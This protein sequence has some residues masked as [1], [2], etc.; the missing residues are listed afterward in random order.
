MPSKDHFP[1]LYH[2]HHSL[3]A[4]DLP[5]WLELASRCGGPILE[6][7]CGTGRVLVPLAEAGHRVYG[8]DKDAG[9]LA[10]LQRFLN[11]DIKPRVHLLL[12]DFAAI[13]LLAHF[14]LILMPCNTYS[15]LPQ[16]LRY[17]VL[18]EVK[19][20]LSSD[21]LFAASL[22]NPEQMRRLPRQGEPQIEDIFFH[23]ADGEPVQ[24]SSRW[25]RRASQLVIIWDYDHLSPDGRVERLST[26]VHHSLASSAE[27][28]AEFNAAGLELIALYGDYD[29]SEY[30][31]HSPYLIL[32]AQAADF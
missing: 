19:A 2:A 4:E 20:C 30:T 10:V 26:Q 12:G 23:P 15:T 11:S 6:L 1:L 29:R 31:R 14:N 28:K 24:V 32:L 13:P 22:P 8:L 27:Y 21:G 5:L 3:H 17:Q 16:E 7:G 25:E 18:R 9:M